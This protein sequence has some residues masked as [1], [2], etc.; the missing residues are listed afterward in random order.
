M[1]F[2]HA[3]GRNLKI[4]FWLEYGKMLKVDI[5]F[6]VCYTKI[7]IFICL[8]LWRKD[9]SEGLIS[10]QHHQNMQHI[11]AN[12]TSIE[13]ILRKALWKKGYRCQKNISHFH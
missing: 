7:K 10:E 2:R 11:H 8:G 1:F 4:H 13:I 3:L 5:H 6:I 12:D 9:M